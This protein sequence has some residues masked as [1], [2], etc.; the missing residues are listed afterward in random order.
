MTLPGNGTMKRI[1]GG[2][3]IAIVVIL[4]SAVFAS[5]S[6]IAAVEVEVSNLK[7]SIEQGRADNKDEHKEI[8]ALLAEIAK[9]VR[10]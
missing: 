10:K 3:V 9:E 5:Q 8:K 1:V 7:Y 4:F 2:I 6:R